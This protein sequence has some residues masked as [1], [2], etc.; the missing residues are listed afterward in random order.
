MHSFARN[1]YSSLR[2][3]G[4]MALTLFSAAALAEEV[5][6][7]NLSIA[8]FSLTDADIAA[9][10][11]SSSSGTAKESL[12]DI[13]R[14][15][16][17]DNPEILIRAN[18]FDA[19]GFAL[20]AAKW[21]RF[22]ALS[23]EGRALQDDTSQ[24]LVNIEQPLW[25]GGRITG[26]IDSASAARDA[27]GS[28]LQEVQQDVL[29]QA[30]GAFFEILR[31]E[32]RVEI[33]K[34]NEAEHVRLLEAIQR[35]VSAE[36]S[37]SAD[38]T[39]AS[40]RM[41]NAM[42]ERLQLERQLQAARSDLERL[43]NRSVFDVRSPA[44]VGLGGWT[45]QSAQEAARAY[46]PTRR[47]LQAE[48]EVADAEI[49][50]SKAEIMP[51]VVLGYQS[52]VGDLQPGQER[53]NAYIGLKAETGAGLSKYSAQ[54]AATARR[55][56]ARSAIDANA[57]DLNRQMQ[58]I[59]SEIQTLESQ[60]APARASAQGTDEIVDSYLRQF[61]V[62]KKSWLDV[63]NAQREKTQA[64]YAVAD[65]EFPLMAAKLR[66]LILVGQVTAETPEA[67]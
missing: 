12:V 42:T 26:Q 50:L 20:D 54:R 49:K 29:L 61:Q 41:R 53:D 28:A 22:P 10:Q 67:F 31:L 46:S 27:S 64:H 4:A 3:A 8:D 44:A 51:N 14:A 18:E 63:L 6:L 5:A 58:I 32:R 48:V 60:L 1:S 16:V 66:R 36:I 37:G 15:A 35:R 59:W 39:Q 23:G 40:T 65:T 17:R 33:A 52:V 11:A 24:L 43:I 2:M 19:A 21:N 38:E 45:L 7:D 13:L 25:T 30:S 47:R 55:Q 34:L 57:R 9:I 62:G 56:A